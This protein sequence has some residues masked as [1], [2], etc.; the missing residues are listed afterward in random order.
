ME[1][2]PAG[3]SVCLPL[4]NFPCTIKSRSSLL[5]P[6]HPRSPGKRAVNRLWWVVVPTRNK[7]PFQQQQWGV[8]CFVLRHKRN[9]VLLSEVTKKLRDN[10][11]T[12]YS[13]HQQLLFIIINNHQHRNTLWSIPH[14]KLASHYII[15]IIIFFKTENQSHFVMTCHS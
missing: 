13:N 8:Y 3:W 12:K 6:A 2:R 9:L 15:R 1:W 10:E 11:C 7:K 4:L 5:A 14:T